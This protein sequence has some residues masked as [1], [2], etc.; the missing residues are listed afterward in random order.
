M[1][2]KNKLL[3]ICFL[4]FFMIF[5]CSNTT[6]SENNPPVIS[7]LTANPDS[8]GYNQTSTITCSASDPDGDNLL[9]AWTSGSGLITGSGST[10]SWLSPDSSGQFLISCEVSD[11]QGAKDN[12]NISIPVNE[13]DTPIIGDWQSTIPLSF[14]RAAHSCVVHNGFL[15]VI[16]GTDGS[17]EYDL[18]DVLYTGINGDGSLNIWQ[19]TT[20]FPE[21]RSNHTSFVH[22]D[23]LYLIGGWDPVVRYSTMNGDGTVGPWD[24]T[25][26]LTEGKLAHSTVVYNNFVYVLGGFT[27]AE[28]TGSDS[29]I[30]AEINPDGSLSDW[31]ST[32]SFQNKR[33]D[34][35]SFAHN[36]I[37]YILGGEDESTIFDDVQYANLNPDGTVDQWNTTTSLPAAQTAHS[38][39]VFDNK[40]FVAGGNSNDIIYTEINQ[41]GTLG[42]WATSSSSFQ[43][44]RGNHTSDINENFLYIIG[45]RLGQ[46]LYSDIQFAQ[47]TASDQD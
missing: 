41:D 44:A 25:T 18:N 35:C 28:Q 29:V 22:N 16:G 38:C 8:L 10:V 3:I 9:Y 32:T 1:R 20:S 36:G 34:H 42:P 12:A 26:A 47:L 11:N 23:R 17:T 37:V 2:V 40:V 46:T 30:F 19:T 43:N 14:G 4:T 7:S 39:F 6:E 21:G 45:G 13:A 33:F 15:Y 5:S 27:D 24:S 31:Q